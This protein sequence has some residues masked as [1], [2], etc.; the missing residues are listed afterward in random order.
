MAAGDVENAPAGPD[1]R[2]P[3]A[4]PGRGSI[5]FVRLRGHGLDY[6]AR[7]RWRPRRALCNTRRDFSLEERPWHP[8]PR[9]SSFPAHPAPC[10][11]RAWTPP[12]NR[13]S[14]TPCSPTASPARRNPR[15]RPSSARPWPSAAWPCCVSTSPGWEEARVNLP[16]RISPRTSQTSSPRPIICARA[17]ARLRS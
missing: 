7:R 6:L 12:R 5:D 2:G 14:P 17:T 13:R 9:R 16:T 11:R 3:P 10:F 8:T 15:R 1:Q 4:H